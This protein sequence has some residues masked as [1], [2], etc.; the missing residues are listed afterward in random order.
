MH[1]VPGESVPAEPRARQAGVAAP[2][3]AEVLVACGWLTA[4]EAREGLRVEELARSHSVSRVVA[5]DGRSA[6][7]KQMAPAPSGSARELR[8]ELFVYRLAG[9]MPAL[10]AVTVKPLLID[11]QH[12]LLVLEALG[13][14]PGWPSMADLAPI[15]SAQVARALGTAM[16]GWHRATAEL[17]LWPSLA[18]GVLHLPEQVEEAVQGRSPSGATFLRWLAG[19]PDF[20]AALQETRSIYRHGCLIHGDLRCDNWIWDRRG[21]EPVLRVLDWEM[22]GGGDP[23]WDLAS[24][25]VEAM[26][27]VV[28][29]G[30][31]TGPS[32]DARLEP[33]RSTAGDLLRAYVA[34][35]GPLAAADDEAWR[36]VAAC[37]AARLLHVA[38]E[39]A[40]QQDHRQSRAI[41]ILVDQAGRLFADQK[42]VATT[43][44]AWSANA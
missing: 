11:E 18:E 12:Q 40:E 38:S 2:S 19:E 44:S 6:V 31:A 1:D 14:G 4:S 33:I 24:A 39:W 26:L 3:P 28:R 8:R 34:A 17:P 13:D 5:P 20:V 27:D 15:G 22:A 21:G 35:D 23:A 42:L 36:R 37:T 7:V 29:A 43:F 10:S 30:A 25:I 41:A 9:W 16:A 32:L